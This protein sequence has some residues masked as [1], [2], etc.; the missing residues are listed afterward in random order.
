MPI[1]RSVEYFVTG[2][3]PHGRSDAF[4]TLVSPKFANPKGD[5]LDGRSSPLYS[6]KTNAS[7]ER[8]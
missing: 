2:V 3:W 5:P 1:S 6:V 8:A 4:D 7:E